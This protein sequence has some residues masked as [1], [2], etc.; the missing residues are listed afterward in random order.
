MASL[1]IVIPTF[2][3]E[4]TIGE[5]LASVTNQTVQPRVVNI[6]DDGSADETIHIASQFESDLNLRIIELKSNTGPWAARNA[7]VKVSNADY[8]SFVDSD[9]VLLAEHVEAHLELFQ[10]GYDAVAT[11]FLD[12]KP[13]SNEKRLDP[14]KFPTVSNREK[15]ILKRNFVAGFSSIRRDVFE[16]LGGFRPEVTEDWDLWIRFFRKKFSMCKSSEPTYLYRWREGSTSRTPEAYIRDLN[17][18]KLARVESATTS[19]KI[20]IDKKVSSMMIISFLTQNQYPLERESEVIY[21]FPVGVRKIH[22]L[23]NYLDRYTP[24]LI[25]CLIMQFQRWLRRRVS[26]KWRFRTIDL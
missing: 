22:S 21:T 18:L 2:N 13:D 6:V 26:V 8:I 4:L 7:G 10:H 24:G 15:L 12:W 9:D 14:R 25:K 3:S 17:T 20:S 5:T 11:N 1:E 19:L 16:E 23:L